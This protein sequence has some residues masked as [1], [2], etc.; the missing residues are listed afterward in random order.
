[1]IEC[2]GWKEEA[3]VILETCRFRMERGGKE[4]YNEGSQMEGGGT[5]S[6][7]Y[8]RPAYRVASLGIRGQVQVWRLLTMQFFAECMKIRALFLPLCLYYTFFYS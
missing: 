8:S 2:L 3:V 7:N 4:N 5:I 6:R 1:M